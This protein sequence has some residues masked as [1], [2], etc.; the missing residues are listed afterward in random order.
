MGPGLHIARQ[1]RCG[2]GSCRFYHYSIRLDGS[3]RSSFRNRCHLRPSRIHTI[4][5]PLYTVSIDDQQLRT[6]TLKNR[7]SCILCHL[8]FHHIS[9]SAIILSVIGEGIVGSITMF[10]MWHIVSISIRLL[11]IQR[12]EFLLTVPEYNIQH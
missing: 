1:V 10:Y 12:L 9:A 7:G 6:N 4:T 11:F 2:G 5:T 3:G 8:H